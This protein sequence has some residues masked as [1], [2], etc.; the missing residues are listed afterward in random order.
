MKRSWKKIDL[1]SIP[2]RTQT[3][4]VPLHLSFQCRRDFSATL[5]ALSSGAQDKPASSWRLHNPRS[6]RS[7]REGTLLE[8]EAEELELTRKLGGQNTKVYGR[9]LAAV[10]NSE[11]VPLPL[12]VHQAVLR[13]CALPAHVIRAY[14]ART[15]AQERAVYHEFTHPHESRFRK[16]TQNIV[17]AG[18]IPSIEDYHFIMNQLAAAGRHNAI[19]KYMRHMEKFGLV[20]DDRTFEFLLQATANRVSFLRPIKNRTSFQTSILQQPR[21]FS[22][23]A[24]A[25][26]GTIREMAKRGILPSSRTLDPVFKVFSQEHE[27]WSTEKLLR[28]SYGI[29]LNYL[30]SPPINPVSASPGTPPK[31]LPGVLPLSTSVLN[32]ILE[33]YGRR[34]LISKM[35][36]IF[37]SL[38]NPLP[39]PAKPDNAFDDDDDDFAP[40]QQLWKPPSPQPNTASFNLLIKYCA[41]HRYHWLARH[42][43]KQVVREEKE[44]ITRLM[45]GSVEKLLGGFLAPRV[46]VSEG[47]LL[48][49][50][51]FANRNHKT[52][53][54]RWIIWASHK[55]IGRKYRSW[56]FCNQTQSKFDSQKEVPTSATS[57]SPESSESST[58]PDTPNLPGSLPSP[59][60]SPPPSPGKPLDVSMHIKI[61]KHDLT[62]LFPVKWHAKNRLFSELNRKKARIWRRI[63]AGKD[64]YLRDQNARVKVDPEEW[65]DKLIFKELGGPVPARPR[66]R[67]YLG[68]NFDPVI[69]KHGRG[70]LN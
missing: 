6:L 70:G 37:E 16:I 27:L 51:H 61:L 55:S 21:I 68:K 44:G 66:T 54:L 63:S 42:Y 48:P 22:M 7:M 36:Y 4:S 67:V 31:R 24:D 20:L 62:K 1:V 50:L 17:N 52:E 2:R 59:T 60:T 23:A 5:P 32:S 15:L 28:L 45:H 8:K 69:A 58:N 18:F 34:G 33:A 39:V 11:G 65:K 3:V 56:A 43:A 35:V 57:D 19:R 25:T 14:S 29:D 40:I 64:V 46:A 12:E 38:T 49:L 26:V 30:D 9:Y 47:T 53:L 13:A 10:D 41:E